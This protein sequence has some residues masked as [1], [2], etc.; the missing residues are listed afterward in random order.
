MDIIFLYL[1]KIGYMYNLL[2]KYISYY[3]IYFNLK[4]RNTLDKSINNY[5]RYLYYYGIIF[6]YV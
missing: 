4:K 5:I 2:N 6:R 1:L 3:Y